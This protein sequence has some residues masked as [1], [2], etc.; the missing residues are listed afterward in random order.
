MAGL[1]LSDRMKFLCCVAR[2]QRF[3]FGNWVGVARMCLT[4][5]SELGSI[6]ASFDQMSAKQMAG[7]SHG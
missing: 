6:T 3:Y 5:F 1:R 2:L 4:S 7:M